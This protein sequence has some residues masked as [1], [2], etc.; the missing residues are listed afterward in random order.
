MMERI[1]RK[2][3]K[4]WRMP[5]NTISVCRPGIWG[6]PFKVGV[7]GTAQECIEAYRRWMNAEIFSEDLGWLE[8]LYTDPRFD[9]TYS[10]NW[11]YILMNSRKYEELRGKNLACFCKPGDPCHADVLLELANKQEAA[12][13]K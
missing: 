7:W 1:Q 8:S 6:N 5:E 2:R 9:R 3:V 13:E 10:P 4:G 11:G 12:G